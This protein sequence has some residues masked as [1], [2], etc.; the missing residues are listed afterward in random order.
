MPQKLRCKV[1][2]VVDHGERVYSV[3]LKPDLPAP[4]FVP[5]QFLHLALDSYN[6]G[7]FW[8]ESRVFSIA[9][10]PA[11]RNLLR[12]TYAVK[13]QFTSRMESE[14]RVGREIWIKL[15]YGEFIV[16]PESDSC[17]LAGGTGMTA[18]TSF[19]AGLP[20]DYPHQVHLFYGARRAELLVYRSLVMSALQR[21]PN[22]HALFFAEQ[23]NSDADCL[24]GRIDLNVIWNKLSNPMTA[25]YYLAGPPEMLRF[26]TQGLSQRGVAFDQI[27]VDAWE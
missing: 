12:I 20:A 1:T 17:L 14:L 9:S 15:P 19:I 2:D 21:C 18:F 22:L 8:P 3:F 26:F 25:T 11:E 27:L 6:P 10:A 7:D 23:L 16:N 13:G 24:S 4:R 5:G